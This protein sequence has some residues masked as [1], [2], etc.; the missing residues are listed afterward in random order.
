[1]AP[2]GGGPLQEEEAVPLASRH[3]AAGFVELLEC[4]TPVLGG[5]LEL[6]VL[7]YQLVK[8][9]PKHLIGV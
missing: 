2:G 9:L 1:M 5:L 4:P 8:L 7:F 6:G 3:S